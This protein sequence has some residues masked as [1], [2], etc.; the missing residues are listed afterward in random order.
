MPKSPKSPKNAPH[1]LHPKATAMWLISNTT[2]TFDQIAKFCGFHPLEVQSMAD[3]DGLNI[4]EMNPIDSEQLSREEISRCEKDPAASLRL[5]DSAVR[6]I[7]SVK[8]KNKHKY[9]PIARRRDKPNAIA[10]LLVNFPEMKPHHV[11]KLLGTTKSMI[12]SISSKTHSDYANITPKDP[13]ILG[14][15]TQ[16][17]LNKMHDIA[18]LELEKE[19]QQLK[20]SKLSEMGGKA[21]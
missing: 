1:P 17:E 12:E 9:I 20:A 15:C 3:D 14:L 7:S 5:L 13:V 2:L 10:W 21:E 4:R 16:I 8:S 18:K 11:V 6:Y 19:E